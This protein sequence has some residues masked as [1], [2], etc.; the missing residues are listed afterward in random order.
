MI[1]DGFPEHS[2]RGITMPECVDGKDIRRC[3]FR[4]DKIERLSRK[5][6][7]IQWLDDGDSEIQMKSRLKDLRPQFILGF[8]VLKTSDLERLK[9]SLDYSGM[10]YIRAPSEGNEYHGLI[11][12]PYGMD[13]R[14]LAAELAMLSE[15][16]E[17]DDA[18]PVG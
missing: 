13:D 11:T 4:F 2:A 7:S 12:I 5:E 15:K 8:A 3:V 18:L 16:Y 9:H 17:F 10:N 14:Q 6:V 1:P